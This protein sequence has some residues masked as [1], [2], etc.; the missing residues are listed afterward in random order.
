MFTIVIF[1]PNYRL[2]LM[3]K[4]GCENCSQS[5]TLLFAF[6]YFCVMQAPKILAFLKLLNIGGLISKPVTMTSE[7]K[8]LINEF[9][10]L[11]KEE[12]IYDLLIIGDLPN[13]YQLTKQLIEWFLSFLGIVR[14]Y[15]FNFKILAVGYN[16]TITDHVANQI[17]AGEVIQRPASAVKEMLENA[18]DSGAD[19][20]QLIVK[21]AGKTLIQV[22]DN[23]CGMSLTDARM[24]FE[25][26][27]TS[28]IKDANDLFAIR[29]MGFRGEAMASMAAIAHIELKTKLHSE[30]VGTRITIEGSKIKNQE[31]LRFYKRYIYF[32]KKPFL[33]YS[34]QKKFSKI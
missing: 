14:H 8:N 16:T 20:I 5:L 19:Q 29:T 12:V 24:C 31:K 30:N 9:W 32:N 10:M 15:L 34:S 27:A 7:R 25:R 2:L 18:I 22:V 17:A 13:A 11:R 1:T 26:H 28:K 23:G 21:D 33:Q 3:L 6:V 4:K